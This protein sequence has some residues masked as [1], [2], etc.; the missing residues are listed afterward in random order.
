MRRNIDFT[1]LAKV[2]LLLPLF[3]CLNIGFLQASEVIDSP[4]TSRAFLNDRA[5]FNYQMFCQ[6]CH[7][8]DGSGYKS[9]PELK[10][11]LHNFMSTQQGREYL[12]RVPGSANSALGDGELA[13]LMN[14]MLKEF[15]K[16]GGPQW[17]PFNA[18]EVGEYRKQ[19][20]NET[21]EYR[22]NLIA[23]LKLEAEL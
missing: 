19:P 18:N 12:I 7:V 15:G 10:G 1:V 13:E 22:K 6:G 8:A 14:W 2:A 9:V 5:K 17:E 3:A 16:D 11:F 21:V 4:A 20:L 23:S